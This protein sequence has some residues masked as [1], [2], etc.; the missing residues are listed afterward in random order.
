MTAEFRVLGTLEVKVRGRV[1]PLPAGNGR[2]ALAGLLLH[3]N[4]VVP[5]ERLVGWL[6]D[7]MPPSPDRAAKS[8]HMTMNRL[9]NALGEANVVSTAPGGYVALVQPAQLDLAR[10]RELTAA[11]AHAEALALWQGSGSILA[12]VRS[13]SLHHDEITPLIEERAAA[14][15]HRLEGD[16]ERGRHL[17]VVPEL[18]TLTREHPLRERFWEHLMLALYRGGRQADALAAYRTVADLLAEE[19]GSTPGRALRELHQQILLGKVDHHIVPARSSPAPR[20]LPINHSHFVGREVELNLLDSNTS[21]AVISGMAGVGKTTLAVWWAHMSADLFPDGQLYVDLRGFGPRGEPVSAEEALR[22]FLDALEI[23]P[24]QVSATAEGMTRQFRDLLTGR[25]MLVLL[26]NARDADQVRQ[27]LS[28]QPGCMTLVTSRHPLPGLGAEDGACSIDLST[29]DHPQSVALLERHL[30]A[31]RVQA[32]S[33]AVQE[34]TALCAGLPLALSMVGARVA[35]DHK[36]SLSALLDQVADEATRLDGFA[37]DD[38]VSTNVRTVFSWSYHQLSPEAAR[39]FQVV[40]LHPGREFGVHAAA[41]SADLS[42]SETHRLLTSLTLAQLVTEH[43]PNRFRLHDLL[44]IYAGELA[45]REEGEAALH[46]VLDQYLHCADIAD[47]LMPLARAVVDIEPLHRPAETPPLRT[48]EDAM[49]WFDLELANI[50]AAVELASP[51]HSW[52]LAYTL[53]RYLWL[54]ADWSTWLRVCH[55]ALPCTVGEPE[56]RLAM[57]MNIGV[58]HRQRNENTEALTWLTKALDVDGAP[59]TAHGRVLVTLAV[60]LDLE[61]RP[62]E[63]AQRFQEAADVAQMAGAP[64]IEAMAR[65]NLAGLHGKQ[66]KTEEAILE[67]RAALD[68]FTSVG[69]KIGALTCYDGLAWAHLE[70]GEFNEALAAAHTALTMSRENASPLH[71]ANVLNRIGDTLHRMGADDAIQHWEQAL[72]IFEQ[73][74]AQEVDEVRAKL[75]AERN[76]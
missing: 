32:E 35:I 70:R 74:N 7:G 18:Q 56:A 41:S 46:R 36:L 6:W 1:I 14:L 16:L 71:E 15:E 57:L 61:N 39:L 26:D 51:G 10:F 50:V 72:A 13:N 24:E 63:S 68:T 54:R 21:V 48:A 5:S 2:I 4:E 64:W 66:G 65:Q 3:A 17:E 73:I 49:A 12:D 22:G 30:G 34:L 43:A 9:R 69:E 76:V 27:L 11:G 44:R 55:L 60:T 59:A 62:L 23:P 28:E 67:Y 58:A 40:G 75:Q 45:G 33:A 29:L 53:S 37:A 47:N 19:L 25:K 52:Q 38:D 31:D 8:L 20:Q 42:V